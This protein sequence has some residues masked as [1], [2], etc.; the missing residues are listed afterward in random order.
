M[1]DGAPHGSLLCGTLG[2]KLLEFI[3]EQGPMA[4]ESLEVGFVG[5]EAVVD[6]NLAPS[7]LVEDSHFYAVAETGRS[8]AKDDVD[9]LDEAVVLDV[10]VRD[11]VLDVLNATVIADGDIMQRGME[12][13]GVLVHSSRHLEALLKTAYAY[14]SRET[15]AANVFQTGFVGDIDRVPILSRTTLFLQLTD[16]ICCEFSCSKWFHLFSFCK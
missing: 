7:S 5:G 3:D 4:V 9:V 6:G 11:V 16:F 1:S 12:D 13:A 2:S 15:G 8:V 14:V 10:I